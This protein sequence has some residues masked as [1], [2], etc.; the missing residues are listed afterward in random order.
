MKIISVCSINIISVIKNTTVLFVVSGMIIGLLFGTFLLKA[1]MGTMP[2]VKDL[3]KTILFM[4]VYGL[5]ANAVLVL[6]S[7]LYN[8]I[9]SF[10][11]GLEFKIREKEENI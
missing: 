6:V 10:T 1:N 5:L 3:T 2:F 4:G 8:L 11:G 9:C 7:V